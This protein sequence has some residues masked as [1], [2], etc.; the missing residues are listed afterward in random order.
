MKK[1][2]GFA[3]LVLSPL[4]VLAACSRQGPAIE[5]LPTEGP[6]SEFNQTAWQSAN[7]YSPLDQINADNVSSL[8]VAWEFHTGEID[9]RSEALVAFEDEPILVDGNLIICTISR[10][11]IALDPATGEQRWEYDPGVEPTGMQKC[12]GVGVWTDARAAADA[13][14]KT[15]IIWATTDNRIIAIDSRTGQAC[16][17]FGRD[18]AVQVE[19]SV[20]ELFRGE[21]T[22]G[23]RPA[24]VNGV[25]VVGSSVADNQRLNGPSGR[26]MAFDARTGAPRWQFDPLPRDASNPAARTWTNG[27]AGELSGA[28][29]WS[30]M[31]V[32][33]ERDLVFLPTTSPSGDFYGGNRPGDNLY[34]DSL[35]ALRGSTGEVVWHFQFVHHN[36]WDYDVPTAPQLIDY[37]VNGEMVPALIQ[38]TK[39]GFVFIFNRETGEPLTP[40]EER[41]VPQEG[42][43]ATEV[44][45]PTQP[46][47]VDMPS[48]TPQEFTEDDAWG[49]T[50]FDRGSCR[51]R[52]RELD[53]GPIYTPPSERGTIFMPGS[54]GGAN[55]GGGAY[56]AASNIL[57]VP[58]SRVPMVVRLIP[59]EEGEHLIDQTSLETNSGPMTFPTLGSPY[60]TSI[61]PMLSS[62]GAPCSA[63]PWAA[64]TALNV[65][66][67]EIVWE[68]PL[69]TIER[70]APV[71]A[72]IALG[73]PGAGGPLAT[74]GGIVFIGYSLDHRFRAFDMRSGEQ[75]WQSDSLP[76][77][78][79]STPITY[80]ANGSQY[81]VIAAGGHSMYGPARSDTV[82]AYRLRR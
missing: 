5:G 79:T 25:I 12:R 20:P 69:G 70:L 1:G 27:T 54:S 13:Q 33:D 60:I 75:L 41:P 15:R 36:V 71:P 49:F 44:L 14:C 11:V 50:P 6:V 32:D 67:R 40:I 57:V 10:R 18:G 3:A 30:T 47:P 9:N 42:A 77:P 2:F 16:A 39:Q 76:A 26:V 24:I 59:R 7:H 82:V 29:V 23:S 55:W 17:G 21:L 35:V 28:N 38:L 52:V 4:L 68:V 37:P 65:V 22:L 78:A 43:I 63:P 58:T 72:P 81:V 46:F 73:T 62:F 56:D 74:A 80:E 64:L 61:E 48:I 19:P 45:S 31:S 66:T 34:A 51:D 8:E 53:H